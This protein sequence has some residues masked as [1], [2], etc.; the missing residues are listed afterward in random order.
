MPLMLMVKI[1]MD[2]APAPLERPIPSTQGL[3]EK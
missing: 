3:R 2:T 1:E